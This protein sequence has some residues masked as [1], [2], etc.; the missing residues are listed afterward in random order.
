MLGL[1]GQAGHTLTA[2]AEDADVVVVNTCAFI[3]RAKQESI[4]AILEIAELKKSGGLKRL[5]VTGCLAER[6]RD[7]LQ[8]QIPEID[9][10]LGTGEVPKIVEALSPPHSQGAD[11]SGSDPFGS[12]PLGSDPGGHGGAIAFPAT[13][14]RRKP[15]SHQPLGGRTELPSYIYDADTPRILATPRHFAYLKVAEGCDYKCAFCIIPR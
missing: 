3:D 9:A 10:L 1:A 8:S 6:Y 5:V 14:Y 12:D 4:D 7:E 15:A 11:P 2:R 13:L